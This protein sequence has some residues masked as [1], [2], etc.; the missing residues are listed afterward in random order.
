MMSLSGGRLQ[1]ALE[2]HRDAAAVADAAVLGRE[3]EPDAARL[4][5][6]EIEQLA[7]AAGAVEQRRRSCRARAAPRRAWQTA[8]GRRRRPPSTL[9]P[10]D[11]PARTGGR[12][13][14]G[15]RRRRLRPRR[16]ACRVVTPM[17]LL[18][19]VRPS[20]RPSGAKDLEHG[21]RPAQQRVGA[22][23]RLDHHELAGRGGGGN[24]RSGEGDDV[25]VGG[26]AR[27]ADDPCLD[28]DGH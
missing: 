1:L 8:R 27:V 6:V 16:T 24:L 25:V 15:T 9:P 2:R 7:A 14:R 19:S 18:S 20:T 12:A 4:E 11:R 13:V 22:A 28:V 10:A 26:E 3:H 23:A 5:P 21:E 17:R